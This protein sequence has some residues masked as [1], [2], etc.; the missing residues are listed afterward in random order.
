MNDLKNEVISAV[1]GL[2]TRSKNHHFARNADIISAQCVWIEYSSILVHL[3]FENNDRGSLICLFSL[4]KC[5]FFI[6]NLK[7]SLF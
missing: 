7:N 2:Q 4:W 1:Q 5:A 6:E 3:L